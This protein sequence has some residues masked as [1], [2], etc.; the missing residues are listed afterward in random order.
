MHES[1][2]GRKVMVTGGTGALGSAVV[3]LLLD[4]GAYCYATCWGVPSKRFV[5]ND[6]ERVRV[7][8]QVDMADEAVASQVYGECDDLWASVHVAGGF[9][10]APLLDTPASMLEAQLRMNTV[11]SFLCCREA[12]RAIQ[13]AG[14]EGGRIVN[15]AAKPA[16]H[17]VA[18]MAAYSMA[19]AA[20]V[21]MTLSLALELIDRNILVNAIVPSIMDTHANRQAMPDADH[22]KWPST[23]DI[24]ATIAFLASPQN[25]VTHGALVP[26]YGRS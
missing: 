17:P 22:S 3:S 1:F 19:K 25:T 21:N 16:V 12:V 11:T 10:M 8:D 6:H 18:G 26:V 7:F 2:E 5:Y 24:A 14:S 13:R 15:V 4:A 23:D 20:V 9:A